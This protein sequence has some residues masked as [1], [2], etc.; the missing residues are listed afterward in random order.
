LGEAATLRARDFTP[1][2]VA[3]TVVGAYREVGG[4]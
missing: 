4:R 3:A 1:E 2:S